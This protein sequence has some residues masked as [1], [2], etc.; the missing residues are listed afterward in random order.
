[1][2]SS[3]GPLETSFQADAPLRVGPCRS[4]KDQRSWKEE[5]RFLSNLGR[6]L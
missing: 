5:G 6:Q 1:M 4:G 3:A 2:G